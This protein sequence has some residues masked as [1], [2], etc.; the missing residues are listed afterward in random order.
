M[1][2]L[3]NHLWQSTVFA[4][5]V[6]LAA[7]ALRRNS[8]RLRYWLWL[9][10]SV[11]FLI[12]ITPLVSM[13]GKVVMPPDAPELPALTVIRVSTYFAPAAALPVATPVAGRSYWLIVLTAI[14]LTGSFLLLL[15][16]FGRWYKI[17]KA[18]RRATLLPMQEPLPVLSLPTT[19]EPAIFGVFR[20]VLLLPEGIADR[21]T[22]EQFEAVLTHELCHVRYRDNLTAALHMCVETIFWF[23]PLVWWIG[24]K[25]IEERERDCDETVLKRGSQPEEYAQGIVNVCK[26]CIESPLPCVAGISGASLKKRIREIMTWRGSMPVSFLRKLTLTGA[27]IA[28]VTVPLAIG[29]MRAQTLPPP[30]AYT[31]DVVSIHK[32]SP[33]Q[34]RVLIGPGPQGGLRSQN[35]TAMMLLTYAYQVR[36]YQII[37]APGWVS[38]DRFDVSLT[39]DKAEVVPTPGPAIVLKEVDAFMNR[40]Q[41]RLQAVLRDRF[42]L[43]LRAETHELPIYALIPA[44][45]GHKLSPTADANL[46]RP[47]LGVRTGQLTAISTTTKMLVETLSSLVGRPV[48]NETGLDG[49][50]DFMIEWTPD[51]AVQAA[52]DQPINATGGPSLFTALTEQLGLRLEARKGPVPVYVIEKIEKPSEN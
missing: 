29:I 31:Y 23:H 15:R 6:A 37:G 52:P 3:T 48:I 36:D 2:D 47:K 40:N 21:L 42:G 49:Q 50:Y 46:G 34:R 13:G 41:Q 5:V 18:A 10:A 27:G 33:D 32:S 25:L 35:T 44:K 39:P 28:V 26:S 43:I 8:A 9:A 45:G 51:S 4:A 24:A 30:P 19:A 1:N 16:W 7:M 38:S 17:H 20:P 14:W 22:P 12:P 11:K